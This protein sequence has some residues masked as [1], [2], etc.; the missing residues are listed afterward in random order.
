MTSVGIVTGA[1]SGMGATCA[2][3]LV[4]DVNVL[5]L[6]DRNADAVGGAAI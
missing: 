3:R 2:A 6:A 5:I 4:G 1:S